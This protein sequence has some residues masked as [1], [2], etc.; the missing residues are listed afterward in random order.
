ML[1]QTDYWWTNVKN[2]NLY[3]TRDD[4]ARFILYATTNNTQSGDAA[5][6][7]LKD[8]KIT[9]AATY[10]QFGADNN[11]TR[12]E[13]TSFLHRLYTNFITLKPTFAQ[14][15]DPT[16]ETIQLTDSIRLEY[17]KDETMFVY[18]HNQLTAM[19]YGKNG[20]QLGNVTVGEILNEATLNCPYGLTTAGYQNNNITC[21][22]TPVSKYVYFVDRLD[23]DRVLFAIDIFKD[24]AAALFNYTK[25]FNSLNLDEIRK[26]N[27]IL[28]NQTRAKFN[29]A[30]VRL[31]T[32]LTDAA[33]YHATD[34]ATN[35]FFS[36]TNL[37]GQSPSDRVKMMGYHYPYAAE[38]IFYGP[39]NTFE[40]HAGW[41]NSSGHRKIIISQDYTVIGTGIAAQKDVADNVKTLYYTDNF[42]KK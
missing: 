30:P 21:Q 13:A 12:A 9:T 23:A 38:I 16:L 18:D 42:T 20:K 29:V 24:G 36:H 17:T 15:T 37:T 32:V 39:K 2:A 33:Q 5:F 25:D 35:A 11:L 41:M 3:I 14:Q 27:V 26:L 28:T 40:V 34:M 19:V 7:L 4:V 22:V 31:D 6:L 8:L 1:S 10:E